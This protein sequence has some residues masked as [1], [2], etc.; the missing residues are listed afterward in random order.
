MNNEL[1]QLLTVVESPYDTKGLGEDEVINAVEIFADRK[2]VGRTEY[3]EAL[4]NGIN[5]SIIFV[6]NPDDFALADMVVDKKK[7]RAS[8]IIYDAEYFLIKRTY[9]KDMNTMEIMCERVE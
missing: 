3:Y 7:H 2:S 5:L 6:I 4:R 9:V 1:I 8:K